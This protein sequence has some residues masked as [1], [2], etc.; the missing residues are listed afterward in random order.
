MVSPFSPRLRSW[1]ARVA[2]DTWLNPA[3]SAAGRTGVPTAGPAPF[4][5]PLTPN[6]ASLASSVIRGIAPNAGR[7]YSASTIGLR[8]FPVVASPAVTS[9]STRSPGSTTVDPAGVPVK[10]TSPGSRVISRDRSA[11]MSPR[12]KSSSSPSLASCAICPFFQVRRRSVPGSISRASSSR[13]PSG[14]SPSMPLERT[15]PPRSA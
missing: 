8:S 11:T 10:M 14:V 4:C 7:G 1:E 2:V 13:G 3:S 5:W 6:A 12:P 9:I 15:L